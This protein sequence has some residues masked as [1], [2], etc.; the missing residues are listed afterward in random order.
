MEIIKDKKYSKIHLVLTILGI[1]ATFFC[2][3]IHFIHPNIEGGDF[4]EVLKYILVNMNMMIV[5]LILFLDVSKKRIPSIIVAAGMLIIEL[6]TY[7]AMYFTL[8]KDY[9]EMLGVS[10]SKYFI[11]LTISY[12]GIILV[13]I[14]LLHY[15]C[16]RNKSNAFWKL[17][18]FLVPFIDLVA[19]YFWLNSYSGSSLGEKI[20]AYLSVH[21][22]TTII[23]LLLSIVLYIRYIAS[24]IC[25][26]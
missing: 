9:N 4:G 15:L 7:S 3:R 10:K 24:V 16:K 2:Y 11:D 1:A 13:A 6:Y 22:S 18:I 19:N 20:I 14:I 8:I 21:Y 5:F 17:N 12:V 26:K 25:D 23:W